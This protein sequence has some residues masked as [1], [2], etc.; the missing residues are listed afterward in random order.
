VGEIVIGALVAGLGGTPVGTELGLAKD[1]VVAVVVV[2]M[3]LRFGAELGVAVGVASAIG[4]NPVS[5]LLSVGNVE[6]VGPTTSRTGVQ[7]GATKLGWTLGSV[8]GA[9]LGTA[10]GQG[11]GVGTTGR[12]L[13]REG[14]PQPPHRQYLSYLFNRRCPCG[15]SS[16]IVSAAWKSDWTKA[17]MATTTRTAAASACAWRENSFISTAGSASFNDRENAMNLS[18]V[19]NVQ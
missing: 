11:V 4:A 2:G 14:Q 1:G 6:G 19:C 7:L 3:S 13:L 12:A 15:D 10:L 17:S 18:R 5:I 8:L 16:V 9:V